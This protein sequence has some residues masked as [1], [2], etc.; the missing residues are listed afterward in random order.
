MAILLATLVVDMGFWNRQL[1][2]AVPRY[3]SPFEGF[4]MCWWT[5][6]VER[7]IHAKEGLKRIF[8]RCPLT[9]DELFKIDG[10]VHLDEFESHDG[11]GTGMWQGVRNDSTEVQVNWITSHLVAEACYSKQPAWANYCIL[12]SIHF[13]PGGSMHGNMHYQSAQYKPNPFPSFMLV[14]LRLHF[15]TEARYLFWLTISYSAHRA[16]IT[17]FGNTKTVGESS[18]T[19][20]NLCT[21][22]LSFLQQ[23]TPRQVPCRRKSPMRIACYSILCSEWIKILLQLPNDPPE[24]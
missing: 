1:G 24:T 2:T 5:W 6:T 9:C 22:I 8:V 21:T 11:L 18:D 14:P 13:T 15:G 20:V 12:I 3:Q 16:C 17:E 7:T 23:A 19:F 10:S 4:C